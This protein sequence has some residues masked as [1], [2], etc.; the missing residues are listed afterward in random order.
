M[1]GHPMLFQERRWKIDPSAASVDRDVLAEIR[2]LQ[3]GADRVAPSDRFRRHASGQMEHHSADWVCGSRA[4]I[5]EG[6]RL[7]VSDDGLVL[8]KR[9]EQI[10]EGIFGEIKLRNGFAQCY[11]NRVTNAIAEAVVEFGLPPLQER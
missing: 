5:E 3:S 6:C 11:K 2:Q 10:V 7:S 8:D 1:I 4:V 9:R